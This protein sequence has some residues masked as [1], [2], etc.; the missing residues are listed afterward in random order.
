[1]R[2]LISPSQ[3]TRCVYLDIRRLPGAV[4]KGGGDC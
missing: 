1:M 2:K 3:E 4:V